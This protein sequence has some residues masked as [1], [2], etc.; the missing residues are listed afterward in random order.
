[1]QHLEHEV[2]ERTKADLAPR[3]WSQHASFL[4]TFASVLM[5]ALAGVLTLN[6]LVD[7]LWYFSGNQL[8][9]TNE[10][11][12]ERISKLN[13]LRRDP[14]AYDCVIFGPSV[15]TLID[16]RKIEGYK[17]FNAGFSDAR[18]EE[19][20][21]Y[22]LYMKQ[23][24][25]SA[26]LVIVDTTPR[27]FATTRPRLLIKLPEFISNGTP[28]VSALR[29]YMSV[30][31][32][33]FSLRSIAGFGDDWVLYD[34]NFIKHLSPS[35][36]TQ[37]RQAIIE[38]FRSYGDFSSD[39]IPAYAELLSI[40][41]DAKKIGIASFVAAEA[42]LVWEEAGVLENYLRASYD[43]SRLFDSY[44]DFTA[45]SKI[46]VDPS[47]SP[48]GLH[49]LAEPNALIATWISGHKSEVGVV[50]YEKTY[51]SFRQDYVERL[52]RFRPEIPASP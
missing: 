45:P 30:D 28:P 26:K 23:L 7:P 51:A 29:A 31:T 25:L 11:F 1:M 10:P 15:T 8:S 13:L 21:P 17:C 20:A 39:A 3:A 12:N 14:T 16:Q 38:H 4:A 5:V 52:E 37:S 2:I 46:S 32:F 22:A 27:N 6:I 41:P 48:D 40:W 34:A 33:W 19:L 18:V 42:A 50:P 43:A 24:G 47:Q 44:C 9:E 49:F 36:E 35:F